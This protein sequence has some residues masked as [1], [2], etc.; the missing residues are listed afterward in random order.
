MTVNLEKAQPLSDEVISGLTNLKKP[1]GYTTYSAYSPTE[2]LL[3]IRRA[4]MHLRFN[5]GQ[6]LTEIPVY[7][8]EDQRGDIS[9]RVLASMINASINKPPQLDTQPDFMCRD[10]AGL[11][12]CYRSEPSF[13]SALMEL[14]NGYNSADII[15]DG[16]KPVFLAK[17]IGE[18]ACLTL[19]DVTID[20][21]PYPPG[22]IATYE[23]DLET[24]KEVERTQTERAYRR[25]DVNDVNSLGFLRLSRFALPIGEQQGWDEYKNTYSDISDGSLEMRYLPIRGI[26]SQVGRILR[27]DELQD[28][29]E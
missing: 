6:P 18:R 27:R 17:Q 7:L 3:A 2:T 11:G 13:L 5:P 16:D 24:R 29:T 19:C 21:V 10:P 26:V 8:V 23:I 14:R 9:S 22:S 1:E 20:G 28:G 15:A 4:G 12:V 25:Y